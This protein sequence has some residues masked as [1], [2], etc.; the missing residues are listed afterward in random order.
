MKEI[1]ESYKK[2]LENL[3]SLSD[4]DEKKICVSRNPYT[5][6]KPKDLITSVLSSKSN[7]IHI[8][9]PSQKFKNK[10]KK[11]LQWNKKQDLTDL[12][13]IFLQLKNRLENKEKAE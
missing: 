8:P 6:K 4:G 3:D 11:H 7:K 2:V 10:P 9:M 1:S 5:T 13:E 12:S